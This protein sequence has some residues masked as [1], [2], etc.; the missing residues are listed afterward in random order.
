MANAANRKA[1]QSKALT[2][3]HHNSC[4][5]A[6]IE[7]D[8]LTLRRQFHVKS[9]NRLVLQI[10]YNCSGGEKVDFVSLT[11]NVTVT[12]RRIYLQETATVN[13]HASHTKSADIWR[14][15]CNILF[16]LIICSQFHSENYHQRPRPATSNVF[17]EC[18]KDINA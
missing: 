15:L 4:I 6:T 17:S 1:F 18:E 16:S 11:L 14:D 2:H 13:A 12:E 5:C 9:T 7:L 8:F 3:G 10:N